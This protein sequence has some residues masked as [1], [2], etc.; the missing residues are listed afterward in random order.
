[1][2]SHCGPPGKDRRPAGNRSPKTSKKLNETVSDH[3]PAVKKVPKGA[4]NTPETG[5]FDGSGASHARNASE[6]IVPVPLANVA[7]RAGMVYHQFWRQG[8]VATYQ[9]RGEGNRL[10]FEVFKIQILPAREFNAYKYP[11]RKS[12]PS[13]SEWGELGFTYTKNSHLDPLVAAQAR[14]QQ[15]MSGKPNLHRG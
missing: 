13:N 15:F 5:G 11:F 8:D 1:M 7:K 6:A 10:E 3:S 14:A 4:Q 9:A 12:F 2:K